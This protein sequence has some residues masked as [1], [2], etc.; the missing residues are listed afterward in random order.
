VKRELIVAC[1]VDH[2]PDHLALLIQ[3]AG[4]P[5]LIHHP[6]LVIV[7]EKKQ[8]LFA[9]LEGEAVFAMLAE[10]SDLAALLA[11]DLLVDMHDIVGAIQAIPGLRHLPRRHH[12][13]D[14][15]HLGILHLLGDGQGVGASRERSCGEKNAS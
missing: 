5:A 12:G 8:V 6:V 15:H 14:H 2:L 13:A 4:V 10:D 1:G 7:G 11:L 3:E 9:G